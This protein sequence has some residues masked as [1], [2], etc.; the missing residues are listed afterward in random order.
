MK[1]VYDAVKI[2]QDLFRDK[3]ETMAVSG[4]LTRE[5]YK[6]FLSMQY[7]LTKGVQ[8]H[9]MAIAANSIMAKKKDLRK[10]LINFAQE[11]EFHFEIAKADL[12]ELD[13]EPLPIPFDT[14]LWW[15]YFNSI[16]QAKPF[17]RLG[18][19]C[20]LE[21]ISDG[22]TDLLDK[23]IQ[24]SSFLNPK[25]LRFLTIHRHG[26]NLAHGDQVLSTLSGA[27]LSEDELKDVLLGCDHATTLYMRFAHWIVEGKDLR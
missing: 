9:F 5:R 3:V 24:D 19:T 20:I 15:A 4:G 1:S 6:R 10:W 7:H 2:A 13:S 18:A 11:E 12:K 8:T 23:L 25:N 14:Q 21:N 17:I 22:S 26:P 16:I 27:N